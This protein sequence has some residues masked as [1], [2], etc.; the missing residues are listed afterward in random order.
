MDVEKLVQ[1]SV[2]AGLPGHVE[3]SAGQDGFG[4]PRGDHQ[5]D[6]WTVRGAFEWDD[7]HPGRYSENVQPGV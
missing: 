5:A 4:A 7:L 2:Y 3:Q 6:A 1:S